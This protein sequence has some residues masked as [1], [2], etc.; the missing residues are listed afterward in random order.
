MADVLTN[1]QRS[2]CMASVKST[3]S[4][5]ELKLRSAI[6]ALGFRYRLHVKGLPGTPD[7]VFPSRKK[8]IFVN[9]CFWHRHSCASG[10]SIP[11]TRAEFWLDKFQQNRKRDRKNQSDLRA[12]GWDSMVVWECELRS[13]R[14]QSIISSV[15]RFL[16]P[17]TS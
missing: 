3:N 17:S 11:Q 1:E 7:L 16:D 5:P 8:A 10:R 13:D 6:H 9:G 4:K 2:R 14:M 15:R 12:N